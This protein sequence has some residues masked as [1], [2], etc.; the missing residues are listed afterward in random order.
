MGSEKNYRIKILSKLLNNKNFSTL[1][2]QFKLNPWF[3]TG[4]TD[5]EGSFVITIYK[6][7]ELKTG[8]RVQ[9]IFQIELHVR[10]LDLLLELQKS[11]NGCGSIVKGKNR[12]TVRFSVSN[13]KDLT[14]FIIPHFEKYPLLTQKSADFILF[15]QIVELMNNNAHLSKVGLLKIINIKASMN[16]GISEVVK[17][18]ILNIIPVERPIILTDNIPNPNWISG[19]VSGDGNFDVRI[20]NSSK[21]KTG[22]QVSLRFRISQHNKDIKLMELL[23]KYFGSG[24][25]E[26]NSKDQVVNLTISKFSEITKIIIPFFEIN[27]LFGIKQLDYLDWCKIASLMKEGSHL[28]LEGLEIIRTIKAGMNKGRKIN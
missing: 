5:S 8:W 11:F 9:A 7:K 10:D 25:I 3:C 6:N 24:I 14:T 15:K 17:K 18:E 21:N 2:P 20:I 16:L 1:S 12:N 23:I 22:Y 4:F 19:F 28:K 26:Q 27:S 13:I